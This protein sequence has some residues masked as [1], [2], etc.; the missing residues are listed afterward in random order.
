MHS[1]RKL[2]THVH[3]LIAQSLILS[4]IVMYF[5]RSTVALTLLTS[6]SLGA[7]IDTEGL[8]DTGLNTTSW[9]PGQAPPL[10][11]IFNLHDMQLAAK[12]TMSK[13][14]YGE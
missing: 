7:V 11:D 14:G 4:A 1:T 2:R 9:V 5:L 8:P 12:N 10:A 13:S 3:S 6:L